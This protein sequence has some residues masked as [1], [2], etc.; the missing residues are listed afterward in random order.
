MTL[1]FF[2]AVISP[3]PGNFSNE[4]PRRGASPARVSA[5]TFFNTEIPLKPEYFEE[6]IHRK[7]EKFEEGRKKEILYRS[8]F[9][10]FDLVVKISSKTGSFAVLES[11]RRSPASPQYGPCFF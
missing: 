10:L 5:F 3:R 6:K 1:R 11:K 9:D 8:L 2:A 4:L 7:G